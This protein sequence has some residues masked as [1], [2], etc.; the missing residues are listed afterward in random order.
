MRKPKASVAAGPGTITRR[1][2]RDASPADTILPRMGKATAPRTSALSPK[3]TTG[4]PTAM[5]TRGLQCQTTTPPWLS[6]WRGTF[7]TSTTGQGIG[8]RCSRTPFRGEQGMCCQNISAV[9]RLAAVAALFV[10]HDVIPAVAFAAFAVATLGDVATLA[11]A[12]VDS[13]Q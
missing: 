10:V 8:T 5:T 13:H 12:S 3:T 4:R 1:I 11:L 9:P 7:Q 6:C 2:G